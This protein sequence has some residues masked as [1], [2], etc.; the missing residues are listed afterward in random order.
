MGYRGIEWNC[1]M[2]RCHFYLFNN[3]CA[4]PCDDYFEPGFVEKYLNSE[5]R[6]CENTW[7]LVLCVSSFR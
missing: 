1:M 3:T 7:D 2:I 4:W 6:Y 5:E